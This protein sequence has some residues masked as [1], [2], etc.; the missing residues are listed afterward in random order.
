MSKRLL[1]CE[2][3]KSRMQLENLFFIKA[4]AEEF[5]EVFPTNQKLSEIFILF[6]DPWPKRRHYKNRLI[7]EG[8]LQKLAKLCNPGTNI[9]FRTDNNEYFDWTIQV[10]TKTQK[11]RIFVDTKWRFDHSTVFQEFAKNYRSLVAE[12]V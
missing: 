3:K 9:F 7:N 4:K 1:A 11:F 12:V 6:P 10:F 8:F 2:Q 5:I